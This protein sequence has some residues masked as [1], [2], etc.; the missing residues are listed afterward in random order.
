MK[1]PDN[2]FDRTRK[3]NPIFTGAEKH[4]DKSNW[5]AQGGYT[6]K[7]VGIGERFTRADFAP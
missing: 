4:N 7:V 2:F 1:L 6:L 3:T 5:L